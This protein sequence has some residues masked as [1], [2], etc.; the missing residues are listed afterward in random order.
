MATLDSEFPSQPYDDDVDAEPLALPAKRRLPMLT[1]VL[2]VA[3]LVAGAFIVGAEVQ[4]HWGTS[5]SGSG[6]GSGTS[7]FASRFGGA[8]RTGT[9]TTGS[10]GTRAGA[11]GALA[12]GG[13]TIGTVSVIKGATLYV[14]DTSGNTVKVVVPVGTSVSK[15]VTT[16]VKGIRP[17]QTVV[18]RGT[19][20]KNG[21]V[22]AQ[23]ITLGTGGAG[24]F[25]GGFGRGGGGSGGSGFGGGGSSGGGAS[26]FGGGST[27]G[28]TGFGGGSGGGG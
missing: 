19:T 27:G 11:F 2:A 16:N 22:T 21:N 10:S 17:G 6:A 28:A 4:K 25:F 1:A 24:G 23:S 18:V 13:A 7:S 8:G 14:T 3:L 26:G 12:G 15:T 20:G 9:T 5:S